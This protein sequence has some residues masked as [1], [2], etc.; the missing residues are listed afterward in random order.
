MMNGAETIDTS[1]LSSGSTDNGPPVSVELDDAATE[2]LNA[3][4]D[5]FEARLEAPDMT[6]SEMTVLVTFLRET[7]HLGGLA[8]DIEGEPNE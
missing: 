3:M 1:S 8:K 2:L 4:I 5:A 6:A 7:G